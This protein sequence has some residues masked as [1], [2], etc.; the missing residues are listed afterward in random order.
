MVIV[1]PK[2]EEGSISKTQGG[3][4]NG[5]KRKTEFQ[6]KQITTPIKGTYQKNEPPI[7]RLSN[8][9]FRATLDKGICFRCNE[10]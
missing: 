7:K 3:S 2:G 5:T 4:E 8:A 1:E 6:M 9:E 10:N